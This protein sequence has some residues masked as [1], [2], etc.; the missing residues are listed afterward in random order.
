MKKIV[1]LVV[2]GMMIFLS[3][4]KKKETPLS[5][6]IVFI[7]NNGTIISGDVLTLVSGESDN[8]RFVHNPDTDHDDEDEITSLQ[9][10]RKSASD[11]AT[12][13]IN[14]VS[15]TG[16]EQTA[17]LEVFQEN[18]TF[19]CTATTK[20][21]ES[22]TKT[23][24]VTVT[25]NQQVGSKNA[26]IVI[27]PLYNG[28]NDYGKSICATF[29]SASRG[30]NGMGIGTSAGINLYNKPNQIDGRMETAF[31]YKNPSDGKFYLVSP[32]EMQSKSSWVGV[33]SKWNVQTVMFKPYSGTLF[34]QLVSGG[35]S[36]NGV[37]WSELNTL[38]LT[39]GST[40]IEVGA[41][42]T[43][44]IFQTETGKKGV[45]MA[46]TSTNYN[47]T[48]IEGVYVAYVYQR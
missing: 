2:C 7:R 47:G 30:L 1:L 8:I 27:E 24:T 5:E 9:I 16:A 28:L 11:E 25:D 39:G 43:G 48:S 36:G 22:L 44:F 33:T 45:G 41:S 26:T 32:S 42:E 38:D 17:M 18:V 34:D 6:S 10:T 4:K 46:Y 23:L 15:P 35:V 31:A 14:L 20:G 19:T 13:T 29:W 12:T 3:C 40:E 37:T 21:G